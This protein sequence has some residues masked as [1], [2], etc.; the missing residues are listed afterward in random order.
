[1]C[2]KLCSIYGAFVDASF[3]PRIKVTLHY[4]FDE[5]VSDL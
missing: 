1:M 5:D 3:I 2:D 4:P